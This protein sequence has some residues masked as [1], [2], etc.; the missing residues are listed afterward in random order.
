MLFGCYY[1]TFHFLRRIGAESNVRV[2]R[3][4]AVDMID[5]A[6][7]WSRLACPALPS[8][9]HVLAGVMGWNALGW[10]DRLAVLQMRKVIAGSHRVAGRG[11]TSPQADTETVRAWLVRH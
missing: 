10:R 11:C 6:G 7:R 1:E 2:Q 5:R 3:S 9:F 8:P 4:L